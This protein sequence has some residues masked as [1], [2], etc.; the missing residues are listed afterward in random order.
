MHVKGCCA[1]APCTEVFAAV[2]C[3]RQ[4]GVSASSTAANAGWHAN[5]VLGTHT[6][7]ATAANKVG[8]SA[9]LRCGGQRAQPRVDARQQLVELLAGQGGLGVHQPDLLVHLRYD[10]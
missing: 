10:R 7:T 6:K 3:T 5:S 2:P 8:V 1:P 4:G 9:R